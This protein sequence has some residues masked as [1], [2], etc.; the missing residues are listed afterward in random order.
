MLSRL[1]F[2]GEVERIELYL[3]SLTL[4]SSLISAKHVGGWTELDLTVQWGGSDTERKVAP[5]APSARPKPRRQAPKTRRYP[6]C[7]ARGIGRTAVFLTEGSQPERT[8]SCIIDIKK[9]KSTSNLTQTFYFPGMHSTDV[10]RIV[11]N[12]ICKISTAVFFVVNSEWI[13]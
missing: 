5:K 1:K 10:H 11:W 4:R 8:L 12:A 2:L 9:K 6:V 13:S 7:K 3:L